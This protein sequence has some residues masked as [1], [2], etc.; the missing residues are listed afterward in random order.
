MGPGAPPL[1]IPMRIGFIIMQGRGGDSPAEQVVSQAQEAAAWAGLQ[2]WARLQAGP[3]ILSAAGFDWLPPAAQNLPLILE[4]DPP[5]FHFGHHLAQIIQKHALEAVLYMGGGSAALVPMALWGEVLGQLQA[6][7]G[8]LCLTNN[9]HSSDWLAFHIRPAALDCLEK[10]DRDNSLAWSLG[11]AGYHVQTPLGPHPAWG[12]DIDTPTDVALLA[13]H[14]DCPPSLRAALQHP[15]LERIPLGALLEVFRRGG[16]QV[17]LMGRVGPGPWA[18]LSQAS[19]TWIRVYAEERGMV[20]SYRAERG[21]VRSLMG[22]LIRARGIKGFFEHLGEVCE[23][24]IIDSRV[25]MLDQLKAWPSRADRFASDL[26]LWEAI[27]DP[28]LADFTAAAAESPLSIL[29][30]GHGLVSGGLYVL[31]DLLEAP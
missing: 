26:F 3:L 20:A 21:E 1:L 31:A 12:L 11:E 2:T 17:A 23:A 7:P 18:A 4:P 25:L 8:P 5:A 29:L 6:G 9:R 16:G 13:R 24:A 19:Q 14:P 30:G 28:W 15:L 22:D 10:A 27:Q